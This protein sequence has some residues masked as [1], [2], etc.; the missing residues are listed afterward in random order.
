MYLHS[1][2]QL[3]AASLFIKLSVQCSVHGIG[4][5]ERRWSSTVLYRMSATRSKI[6]EILRIKEKFLAP[7]SGQTKSRRRATGPN[8]KF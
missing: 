8:E 1:F 4:N 2:I 6:R 7:P 5:L 3:L